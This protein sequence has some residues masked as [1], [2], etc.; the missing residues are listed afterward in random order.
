MDEFQVN[1]SSSSRPLLSQLKELKT[2]KPFVKLCYLLFFYIVISYMPSVF[3][4][5]Y[6][7]E[8]F[9]GCI[10]RSKTILDN[11]INISTKSEDECDFD[12]ASWQL[13]TNLFTSF[14]GLISFL[15]CGFIGRISDAY[16]RK[17]CMFINV[18]VNQ[19][20]FVPIIFI[21]NLWVYFIVSLL[22]G[23][24]G[25]EN[26]LTPIMAAYVSDILPIDLRT[27]GYGALYCVAGVA[28]IFGLSFVLYCTF[29]KHTHTPIY[30][31]CARIFKSIV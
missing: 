6:G 10:D 14:R 26:S 28:L 21:P 18:F 4:S 23:V 11:S 1:P 19:F 30:K 3:M 29:H 5:A 16:G 27:I 25:S 9:G 12:Y 2:Y 13:Y 24:N 31:F 7:A 22:N 17:I 15:F 8:W 20:H